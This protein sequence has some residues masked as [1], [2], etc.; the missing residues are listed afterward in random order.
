[1]NFPGL[2]V[3]GGPSWHCRRALV[4]KRQHLS[5][6]NAHIDPHAGVRRQLAQH[7]AIL[8]H[9]DRLPAHEPTLLVGDFNTLSREAQVRMRQ[10]LEARG[11]QTP[12]PTGVATWRA[13]LYRLHADWIFL[14]HARA[15]RWGIARP[16]GVSDH[17]PVW[18]EIEL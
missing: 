6:Y 8:A 9:A 15:L 2:I 14:R 18:I 4:G 16:L 10:L 1:M 11:Y 13:G 3:P 7:E 17:W 5:I 12:M